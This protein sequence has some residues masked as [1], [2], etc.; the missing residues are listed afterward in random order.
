MLFNSC[1][2]PKYKLY[3]TSIYASKYLKDYFKQIKWYK[4]D[5]KLKTFF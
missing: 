3:N 2:E 1:I 4:L 5:I